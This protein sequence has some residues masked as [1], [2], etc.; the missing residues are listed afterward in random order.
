VRAAVNTVPATLDH[1]LAGQT[2][3]A[4]EQEG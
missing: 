3:P 2:F 4:T 1:P